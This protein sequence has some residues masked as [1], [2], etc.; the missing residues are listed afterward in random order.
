MTEQIG[1]YK[2][3]EN[4]TGY[5]KENIEAGRFV[6][7]K[8]RTTS[9]AIECEHAGDKAKAPTIL[10][11]SQRSALK[12]SPASSQ[13]RLFEVMVSGGVARVLAGAEVKVGE[14][15]RSLAEGKAGVS[16]K[17]EEQT[18]GVALNT[19]KE[20]EYLEVQLRL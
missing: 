4:L 14:E 8:G 16:E 11:V 1:R 6:A 7:I 15:V 2:P 13:D 9:G 17:K 5:A 10:G 19:A 3:G 18:L 20:G 12:A